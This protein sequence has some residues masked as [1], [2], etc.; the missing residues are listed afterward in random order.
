VARRAKTKTPI[1]SP[2]SA[3]VPA[4]EGESASVLIVDDRHENIVALEAVLAPLALHVVTAESGRAA[5]RHLL[6]QD[7][8]VIL[9]DVLMPELDGF[10][11][12]ALIRERVKTR[13]IPIIFLTAVSHQDEYVTRGYGLGAV[14]YI[15]KPFHPE[16]LRA[17]VA[18]FVELFRKNAQIRSQA[19]LLQENERRERE[20]ALDEM[21]RLGETRYQ[22]LAESMP[23]IVWTAGGDG[24]ATYTNRRWYEYTGAE[25]GALEPNLFES[26]VHLDDAA[27]MQSAWR[28]ARLRGESFEIAARFRRADG[29]YRWHLVRA[30]AVTDGGGETT[31]WIGTST[32]IDDRIRAEEALRFLAD[33]STALAESLEYRRTLSD[34]CGLAA[35][36]IAD[37]CVVDLRDSHASAAWIGLAGP[38]TAATEMARR[39]L[40][41]RRARLTRFFLPQTNGA[42]ADAADVDPFDGTPLSATLVVPLTVRG[43]DIGWLRLAH[44]ISGRTFTDLDRALAADLARRI[45]VCVDNARLYEAAQSE[46][47]ALEAAARTKDEFLAVLSHELRSPLHTTLGWAQM[48]RTGKLEARTFDMALDTIERSVRAQVRLVDDLLD[49]S[50]IVTGKLRLKIEPVDLS[51]IIRAS[52]ESVQPAAAAKAIDLELV[53][54]ENG[55]PMRGDASRLQQV[56]WNLLSNA[57]KFTPKNGHIR[58]T[59]ERREDLL[60]LSVADDG[61]GIEPEFLPF[62]FDRFR[63]ANSSTT[64]TYT[65]LGLGLSIVR[66][67]VEL[68]GGHC[69]AESAGVAR[70]TTMTIELPIAPTGPRAGIA[71]LTTEPAPALE[72]IR[73]LLVDDLADGRALF[74]IMLEQA[75][76]RVTTVSTVSEAWK[77][78]AEQLPDILVSDIGLPGESGYDLI[79]RVRSASDGAIRALPAIAL[80]AYAS[81]A[82]RRAALGAGFDAHVGKPI[83]H[84]ALVTALR[85]VLATRVR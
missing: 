28:G 84:E 32:D 49:V 18:V 56:A 37:W 58:V 26:V 71:L 73:A 15:A 82:D 53:L 17:K 33:A 19:L 27:A 9:L 75:G 55:T 44:S 41:D 1:D 78:I 7:F 61:D 63:Q 83:E 45:C 2:A 8:A 14:D 30:I 23:Q 21:R 80:T 46:R 70:G 4:L 62:V 47:T 34:V 6:T 52:V 69:R 85:A 13:H 10:A 67:L 81:E 36:M 43:T 20:R 35:R 24:R 60:R 76:A 51:Q 48:L 39:A 31:E 40:Q 29:A 42:A 54:P 66:H 16:V 11:T 65:G 25:P 74:Q 59:L 12:A 50:S 68:H 64:R 5:L 72:G 79:R 3:P 57:I 22:R 38:S 77:A